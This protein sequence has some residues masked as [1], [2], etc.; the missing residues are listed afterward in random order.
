MVREIS[1]RA[2]RKNCRKRKPRLDER[3]WTNEG[4]HSVGRGAFLV[5]SG[6]RSSRKGD[7]FAGFAGRASRTG[8]VLSF[9][10]LSVCESRRAIDQSE[11]RRRLRRAQQGME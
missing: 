11:R 10:P 3:A 2:A 6:R 1:S 9:G 8:L 7:G 4:L 5:E